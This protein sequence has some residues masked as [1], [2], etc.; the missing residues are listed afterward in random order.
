MC[1]FCKEKKK[2]KTKN[3]LSYIPFFHIDVSYQIYL[4]QKPDNDMCSA[5]IVSLKKCNLCSLAFHLRFLLYVNY[6]VYRISSALEKLSTVSALCT[7]L[8]TMA[9]AVM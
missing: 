6:N 1:L 8:R 4:F 5:L 2:S 9:Q 7:K 3:P